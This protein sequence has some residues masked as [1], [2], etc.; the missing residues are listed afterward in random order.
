[1]NIKQLESVYGLNFESV[2]EILKKKD[3]TINLEDLNSIPS[4]WI[5]AIEETLEISNTNREII[6]PLI[7]RKKRQKSETISSF[8]TNKTNNFYA[9]VKHIG[10]NQKHAFVKRID[11]LN[12]IASL[13]LFIK[14]DTN[15]KLM[16]DC[17]KLE[18]EQIIVCEEKSSKFNI[19]KIKSVLIEGVA[20]NT[21]S[22]L[23]VDWLSFSKPFILNNN[24][25]SIGGEEHVNYSALTLKSKGG[26]INCLPQRN[27][28]NHKI[29]NKVS[30][31]YFTEIFKKE[32]FDEQEIALINIYKRNNIDSLFNELINNQFEK[33]V[34]EITNLEYFLSKWSLLDPKSITLRNLKKT[35]RIAEY[36]DLWLKSKLPLE[37]WEENLI[38]ALIQYGSQIDEIDQIEFFS[39]FEK[40]HIQIIASALTD[41]FKF[42]FVIEVLNQFNFLEGIIKLSNPENKEQLFKQLKE[43]LSP[44]LS[45]EFWVIDKSGEFKKEIAIKT[46]SKYKPEVQS[47]IIS[48]LL[49]D[50]IE[51]LMPFKS[52]VLNNDLEKRL[53]NILITKVANQISCL[54]F[55]IESNG[56]EI[57]ELGWIDN[58]E[59]AKYYSKP[60][61]INE[62]ILIFQNLARN[63]YKIVVG[64][65]IVEW[66]LPILE[67]FNLTVNPLQIWDTL[68]VE[69]FLSP[70]FKSYALTTKHNAKDDAKITLDLFLN[71]VARILCNKDEKLE[72]LLSY[73]PIP[74]VDTIKQIRNHLTFPWNAIDFLNTLKV[75]FF[76]PQP[77]TNVLLEELKKAISNSVH[78]NKLIIGTSNFKNEVIEIE[79]LKLHVDEST[80]KNYN[81]L[82]KS[83]IIEID[84]NLQ[85]IKLAL[86]NFVDYNTSRNIPTYWGQLPTNIKIQVEN[87]INNV[88]DL[89]QPAEEIS[90]T[91]ENIVFMTVSELLLYKEKLKQLKEIE[92]F[93]VQH[94]LIST[95]NKQL[96]KEVSLDFLFNDSKNEDHIW[97]KF[98]GGQSLSPLSRNQCEA[99]KV[100]I[101]ELF[102][103]FW[104]EKVTLNKFKIW[105]NFN[106]ETL[107]D[108]LSL[109][110]RVDI[111]SDINKIRNTQTIFVEINAIEALKNKVIRF[112]PES[113]YRSRYWVFQK[114]LIDQIVAE[115]RST[116]LII[117][118]HDEIEVLRNY[119]IHSGYYIPDN[120]ISI[121]RRMELLHQ[122][123]SK[124]KLIIEHESRFDNIIDANYMDRLNIIYDS[125]NLSEN[126]F[127]AFNSKFFKKLNS[128]RKENLIP[129]DDEPVQNSTDFYLKQNPSVKP[130]I[131]DNFFLLQ[132]LKPKISQIQSVLNNA[133][134]DH[135][136]WV[137]DPRFN[138]FHGLHKTLKAEKKQISIWK[139]HKDYE[140]DVQ[141]ADIHI[142]SVKPIEQIPFDIERIKII[143]KQVFLEDKYEWKPSQIPYLELILK[144]ESDQ[145]ITLP[146]GGGKS[147]L[148]QAPAL[149][150][151]TFTN[152]L[153]IVVTPLKALMEDQ[154]ESLWKRGFFG[155]VEYINSDRSTDVE[156]I[157]RSIAG[158]ELALLFVT[159]ERFRSRSF[160]NALQLRI[161]SNG[162]L[163]YAVFDEAHCVSQWGHEF[164]PDYF[165]CARRIW[166]L[167]MISS[168]KFPLLLFSA[169]VS[170]KIYNDFNTIFS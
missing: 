141:E 2:A 29:I 85:W 46:F 143:L 90:W 128:Q 22:Y 129:V 76:R 165:N 26:K 4:T 70:E 38:D 1:M 132:L 144:G 36:F 25:L 82:D 160:N 138:D 12:K 49:D 61:E 93:S 15:Y 43:R 54:C 118:R 89:F 37:F 114:Q 169:T 78:S 116:V 151:S 31:D 3:V 40:P 149:F 44:E 86:L 152:K 20:I 19:A 5:Q 105:G 72:H 94:E 166:K 83:K 9:Y 137:L 68:R 79:D 18:K 134:S 100:E 14:D 112:N 66:D 103:N 96:L 153:T 13:D 48:E 131:G 95:G 57:F 73:L 41:Y 147:L 119:F 50:E 42:S 163:E 109:T 164:R 110:N 55:D 162:G 16:E 101:P 142:G 24:I 170:E 167:K 34:N 145:L 107:L 108:T 64:H 130:L 125:F 120:D 59:N 91:S 33:D 146:T 139:N 58:K 113:L 63:K 157:Y 75:K 98:S 10:P 60:K 84:D 69:A 27:L 47:Q 150:K 56:K 123:K 168:N 126:Y 77:E 11:D 148:F 53:Y 35:E 30:I 158:G 161:Q 39:K 127:C 117:Q 140:S 92:L 7:K 155:S 122:N 65:N 106:W 156:S 28:N 154:V 81:K 51:C 159:P 21:S 45:F 8:G 88:F 102:D 124:Y 135:K 23:F 80:G 32:K 104:I 121:G 133:D 97:M 136:L 87:N 17:S 6:N 99:L 71:Q 111:R 52:E 115:S 62:G 74:I 67:Q